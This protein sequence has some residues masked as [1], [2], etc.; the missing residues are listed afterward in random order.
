M[1]AEEW[2]LWRDLRLRALSDAPD[3]FGRTFEGESQV[4]DDE[5]RSRVRNFA[6]D[7]DMVAFVAEIDGA[8]GGMAACR[9]DPDDRSLAWLF[10][11]WIAPHARRRGVA[12]A[13]LD[14]AVAWATDHGATELH[15]TVTNNNDIARALY[16]S[17]GF[18]ETGRREPLREG[19]PLEQ[20]YMR[21]H[22]R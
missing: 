4:S 14:R 12:R 3:A 15:L 16:D 7:P 19:S 18:A 20:V 22:L 8:P 2:L 5:W 11:M 9:I 17:L 1:R 21:K 6:S 13:L 10:A